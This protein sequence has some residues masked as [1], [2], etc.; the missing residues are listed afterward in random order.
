MA[1]ADANSHCNLIY[2]PDDA[3]A[4][5]AGHLTRAELLLLGRLVLQQGSK[6]A[7]AG[8]AGTACSA[9]ANSNALAPSCKLQQGL[10]AAAASAVLSHITACTVKLPHSSSLGRL[11]ALRNLQKLTLLVQQSS[12]T[13][14]STYTA[15]AV[16]S[17]AQLPALKSLKTVRPQPLSYLPLT[18]DLAASIGSCS[19]SR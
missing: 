15:A 17:L 13:D 19:S 10:R 1:A 9:Q 12:N 7:A 4:A 5:V 3:L 18:V 14:D 16:A 11:A 8:A 6:K 2:L